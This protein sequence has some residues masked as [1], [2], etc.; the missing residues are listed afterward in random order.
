MMRLDRLLTLCVARPLITAG[1]TASRRALPVLM[2]HS[3]SDDP[4][5]GVAPYYRTA[6]NRAV[7]EA[8][9]CCLSDRGYQSVDLAEAFRWLNTKVP[10]TNKPVVI[11]FDDGFRDFH[12][13]AFPILKKYGQSAVMHLPTAF[14][15]G[16]R[17]SFKG[18]ECM[19]WDEVRELRK[20]GVHFGSHTVS[21]PKL[22]ELSWKE[23][24]AELAHSKENIERELGEEITGFGYPFAFPQQDQRFA[25]KFTQMLRQLGYRNCATTMIGRARPETIR[26]A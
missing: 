10:A 1:L 12:D 25:D 22:Y 26:F 17:R 13:V 2:Y 20:Q 3:V 14:I 24:E 19:T 9:I 8:Q 4:E 5:A 7:F 15:A 21:H 18:R 16:K 11:T 6:T 23:I